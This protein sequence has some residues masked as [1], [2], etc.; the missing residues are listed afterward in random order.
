[1]SYPEHERLEAIPSEARNAV[2][3]FCDWLGEQDCRLGE[4]VPYKTW[5]GAD[6]VRFVP[7]TRSHDELM[8]AFWEIDKVKLNEE[9]EAMLRTIREQAVVR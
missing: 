6:E 1:M 5:T 7:V 2:A 8:H 3:R 4:Y 9:K